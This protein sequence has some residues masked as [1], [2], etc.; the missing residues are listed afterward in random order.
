MSLSIQTQQRSLS[1]PA[2]ITGVGLHSG[3][4]ATLEI[5]PAAV[6]HGIAFERSDFPQGTG[7]IPARYDLV[8]ETRLCTGLENQHGASVSTIEHLMS[9]L[10]GLGID[11]ALIRI[12]GPEVPILDGSA[13]PFVS[14][15]QNAG[16]TDQNASRRYLKILQNVSVAGDNGSRASFT[17]L[18][19]SQFDFDISFAHQAIGQQ[20]RKTPMINGNYRHDISS[21]RT[22][23]FL[24]EVEALKKIGLARGGSLANAIV[25]D[26]EKVL[27][28]EGL[29]FKD[30]FVRHK[31]LDAVGDT[32]LAGGPILACYHGIKAGHALNNDLLHAVFS[33]SANYEWVCA[34]DILEESTDMPKTRSR[35]I[36]VSVAAYQ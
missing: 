24:H 5:L 25:L 36:Y 4:P 18:N 26:E 15:I 19:G 20:T 27:N 10:C 7:R 9:A 21:A 3:I 29:R 34:H 16:I 6:N 32:Y 23:G 12:D 31:I 33:D 35:Q 28:P 2:I 1:S 17:A 13:A 11:N 22:F 30:E 8:T 14:A